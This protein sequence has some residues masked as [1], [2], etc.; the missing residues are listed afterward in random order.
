MK[1]KKNILSFIELLLGIIILILIIKDIDLKNIYLII[2][3][4]K[5]GLLIISL[6]ILMIV[7]IMGALNIHILIKAAKSKIKFKKLLILFN[8]NWILSFVSPIRMH[9]LSFVFLIK[10]E[11]VDYGKGTAIVLLDKFTTMIG[12]ILIS[13]ITTLWIT[14]SYLGY[15]LISLIIIICIPFIINLKRF[16]NK[17]IKKSKHIKKFYLTISIFKKNKKIIFYNFIITIIKLII[18]SLIPY[19]IF[20]SLGIKPELVKFILLAVIVSFIA[21]L[22]ISFAGLGIREYS[23]ILLYQY[24]LNINKETTLSVYLIFLIMRYL[25]GI[26]SIIVYLLEKRF[27]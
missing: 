15:I 11:G 4:A 21:S 27:K 18:T 19:T 2:K 8:F 24:F 26:I 12:L 6:I 13:L 10:Q 3:N 1:F 17:L 14:K 5:I 20:L 25:V 7:L 9:G 16:K 23:A 22:P